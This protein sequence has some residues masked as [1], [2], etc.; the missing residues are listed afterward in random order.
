MSMCHVCRFL[1]RSAMI[2]QYMLSTC[3]PV[4]LLSVIGSCKDGHTKN[5]GTLVSDNK[6]L[7]EFEWLHP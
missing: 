1:V 7:G 4:H 6:D 5:S 2:A 3:L